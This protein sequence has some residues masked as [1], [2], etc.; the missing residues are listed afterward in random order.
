MTKTDTKTKDTLTPR[1]QRAISAMMDSRNMADVAFKAGISERTLY[2]WLRDPNFISAVRKAQGE[3]INDMAREFLAV[4]PVV[5]NGLEKLAV[6]ARS[7]AVQLRAIQIMGDFILRLHEI[8]SVNDR[9]EE[10]ER[11]VFNGKK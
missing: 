4:R 3:A 5:I 10:L 9:L 11:R 7:E 2:R 1:Q 8:S 6:K